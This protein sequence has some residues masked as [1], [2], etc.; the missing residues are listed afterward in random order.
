MILGDEFGTHTLGITDADLTT[1]DS[2]YGFVFG[3]MN[4]EKHV[5]VVSDKRLSSPNAINQQDSDLYISRVLKVSL[6]EEGHNLGLTDHY[7]Y[8]KASDGLLCPMS[9][10]EANKFGYIGYV[11]AVIDGRGLEFCD[12]CKV[13]LER[14]YTRSYDSLPDG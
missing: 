1:E 5:A 7:L 2:F 4:P 12:E 6:H 3:G 10:G 13:F 9:R 14:V 8:K 11:R